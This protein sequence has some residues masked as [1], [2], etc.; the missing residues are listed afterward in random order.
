VTR[1]T[2]FVNRNLPLPTIN[3]EKTVARR[4]H[5][6]LEC[7]P[8]GRPKKSGKQRALIPFTLKNIPRLLYKQIVSSYGKK[9]LI[10]L[11]T[12]LIISGLFLFRPALLYFIIPPHV[13]LTAGNRPV[14]ILSARLMS[15]LI[16]LVLIMALMLSRPALRTEIT[17]DLSRLVALLKRN[18]ANLTLMFVS[19]CVCLLFLEILLRQVYK[20]VEP[21]QLGEIAN[22]FSPE[23]V[24]TPPLNAMGFREEDLNDEIFSDGW[25]R[26]LFLGDSFTF[27]QG[28]ANGANLFSDLIEKRLNKELGGKYHIYN[29]GRMGTEADEWIGYLKTLYST[30]RPHYV[31]A[32]FS[33]RDGAPLCTSLR[34]H[35]E[36]ISRI[37]SKYAANLFYKYFYLGKFI[38]NKLISWEFTTWYNNRLITAYLGS[39]GKTVVW[40]NQQQFLRE[41]QTFCHQNSLELHLI[42][43]PL[44]FRLDRNYPFHKVEGEIIRFAKQA[45]MP[46]CSLTQGFIG[47]V[48]NT[49]WISANDQHPNEKG[50]RIAADTLY[51]YIKDVVTGAD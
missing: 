45:D 27:G 11:G 1:D 22:W 19:L 17:R 9:Y 35:K 18:A 16:G 38:G 21:L 47:Q 36:V 46:V 10:Y 13:D 39:E 24:Y 12:V 33:L 5:R 43:F 8:P 14:I 15:I 37:K 28:V 3:P 29:A 26:I 32:I 7:L 20:P 51:P 2:G 41:M 25:V 6:L 48:D 23:T 30:Y 31:F 49:L 34:C 4:L 42:I 44:L 50:H 40:Q